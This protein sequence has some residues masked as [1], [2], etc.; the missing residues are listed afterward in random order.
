MR[1]LR[2][3]FCRLLA[4]LRLGVG[5]APGSAAYN[6]LGVPVADL[7]VLV[8]CGILQGAVAGLVLLLDSGCVRVAGSHEGLVRLVRT[9][10]VIFVNS[11][12]GIG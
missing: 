8:L 9:S 4:G 11:G 10:E 3:L 5:G 12:M 1:D 2:T 6:D 7:S